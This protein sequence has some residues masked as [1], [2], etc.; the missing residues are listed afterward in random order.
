MFISLV[1]SSPDD[2]VSTIANERNLHWIHT[3]TFVIHSN[4]FTITFSFKCT[5]YYV[6]Y[7]LQWALSLSLSFSHLHWLKF[8]PT[9]IHSFIHGDRWTHNELYIFSSTSLLWL[10]RPVLYMLMLTLHISQQWTHIKKILSFFNSFHNHLLRMAFVIKFVIISRMKKKN[11]TSLF[12]QALESCEWF[13]L[14]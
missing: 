9:L 13:L 12:W 4:P 3:H 2:E 6:S 5:N 14:L 1:L 7:F 10:M 8:P 11:S